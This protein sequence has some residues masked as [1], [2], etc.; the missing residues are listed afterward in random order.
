[1][2]RYVQWA[3]VLAAIGALA[4]WLRRSQKPGK[5]DTYTLGPVSSEWFND[6]R[7]LF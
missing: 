3:S 1:M 7:H 6:N 2:S 4:L 5:L